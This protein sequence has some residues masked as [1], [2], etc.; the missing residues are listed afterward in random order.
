MIQDT[1]KYL[2]I[3]NQTTDE[4]ELV[5]MTPSEVNLQD[6]EALG[7]PKSLTKAIRA[8]CLDCAFNEAEVRKCVQYS[9]P[10][11]PFR[12]GKNPFHKRS[13][14]TKDSQNA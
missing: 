13:K 1:L 2:K 3:G 5:G 11:W 9:C 14:H 12:M 10:L 8:K 4:G 7:H 6:L